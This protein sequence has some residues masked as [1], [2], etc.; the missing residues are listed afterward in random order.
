MA[1]CCR[2][3]IITATSQ[4]ILRIS[5]KTGK[6]PEEF[7]ELAP[8]TILNLNESLVL[9]CHEK[10]LRYDYVLALKSHPCIFLGENSLCTIHEFAPYVCR[11]Y[12]MNSIGKPLKGSKCGL[13]R[14]AAF[15]IGGVSISKEEYSA[16]MK[17][18][19]EKARE[20]NSRKGNKEECWEFLFGNSG[21]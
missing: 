4:D 15:R 18:Y 20:W 6:K 2:D 12:P 8:A 3:Y 7:A 21:E 17:D 5:K 1:P 19:M 11:S 16:Q 10:G 14:G 9:E 13:I